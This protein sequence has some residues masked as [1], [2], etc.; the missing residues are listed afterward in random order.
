M[1][2]FTYIIAE[3]GVNHNGSLDKARELIKVAVEA[4]AN[5]IKFQT[6]KAEKLVR[7]TTP[8]ADY[9][10]K[11]TGSSASQYEMLQ[12]LELSEEAHE[13]LKEL[14]MQK[15]IDFLSSPFDEESLNFLVKKIKVR[16]IKI[17]SGEIT[18]APLLLKIARSQKPA[19]L[20]TGMSTLKEIQ[21]ALSILAFG[22]TSHTTSP[23]IVHF[24]KAFD[25][26]RGK[27]MLRKKVILLHC[28]SEYPTPLE[29]VNLSAMRTLQTKFGLPVGL[30]DHTLGISV[31]IAATA[32]GAC[33][34]EKHFTLDK[35]LPGPDHKA[36]L[37]PNDLK[38]MVHSIREVERAIGVSQ[39]LP[40]I[41]EMKNRFF[42]RRSLV[43]TQN[44]QQGEL[45]HE[46]NIGSKRP[47][48]GIPPLE[49]WNW[50]G[51]KAKKDFLKD[52]AIKS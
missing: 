23:T 43:A 31:P 40:T 41:S 5:A 32:L 52:E 1:R 28:T 30:S 45:F 11:N 34:I 8:M 24:R 15:K 22:Y 13:E 10:K 38:A 48:D 50:L 36:S 33:V 42:A 21:M 37:E 2:Q 29:E 7:A 17:P 51:K 20:S 47:A 4:G 35:N 14:C 39:K 26:I 27:L 46:G 12:K 49:Y 6:F 18:N 25:S 16:S 3:A 44:V 9:Q 19:I